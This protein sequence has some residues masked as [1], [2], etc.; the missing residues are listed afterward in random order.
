MLESFLMKG[1]VGRVCL[2]DGTDS[3]AI[4]RNG[5]PRGLGRLD[6][7][8]R[9]IRHGS[10][11]TTTEGCPRDTAGGKKPHPAADIRRLA[12]HAV[13]W[14]PAGVAADVRADRRDAAAGEL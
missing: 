13:V 5:K 6:T 1:R 11:H 2:S 10:W 14:S 4:L 8:I 9:Q 12:A 7:L 3:H